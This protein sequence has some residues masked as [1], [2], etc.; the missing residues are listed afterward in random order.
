MF[1][2]FGPQPT[3]RKKSSNSSAPVANQRVGIQPALSDAASDANRGGQD[4]VPHNPDALH[5]SIFSPE[6]LLKEKF[7]DIRKRGLAAHKKV[8]QARSEAL[9]V[10]TS[11]VQGK[12][13]RLPARASIFNKTGAIPR[14]PDSHMIQDGFVPKASPIPCFE[15][16]PPAD[17][18]AKAWQVEIWCDWAR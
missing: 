5:L 10:F 14:Y 16:V 4:L 18:F 2:A 17:V 11:F 9:Q 12:S 7:A 13:C 8:E 3:K 1:H 15:W 6:N